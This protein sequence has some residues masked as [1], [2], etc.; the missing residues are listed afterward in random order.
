MDLAFVVLDE[1]QLPEFVHEEI[2]PRP[3]CADHL[4]QH[5]LRD[6]G[7]YHLRFVLLAVP[8]QQQQSPRQPFLAGVE[9]LVNQV[10]FDPNVSS[11]HVCDEAVGELVFLVERAN[12]LVFLNDEHG[13]GCDCGRSRHAPGLA[14]KAPFSKKITRAND[15]HNGFFAGLIHH[16]ELHTA[17]LNVH[18]IPRGS[19]LRED[20]LFSSKL[21]DYSP[22]T[23]RVEEQFHIERKA[24]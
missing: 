24:F 11:K 8:R 6:F 13:G 20:G 19:A 2:D 3:R 21:A 16:C 12:H 4:R 1:A 23:G 22:Q 9:E 10:L 14:R 5:L 17:F 15:R 18:D 7:E